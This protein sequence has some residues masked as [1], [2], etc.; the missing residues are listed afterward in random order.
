MA[1]KGPGGELVARMLAAEGVDTAFGIIDGTYYG[2][3]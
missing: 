1:H 2:L 3:Y